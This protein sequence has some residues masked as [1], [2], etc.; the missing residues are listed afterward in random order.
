MP[1]FDVEVKTEKENAYS[2]VSQNE[3][4]LQFYNLGFFNPQYADQA[5]ACMDM[6]DFKGKQM[7]TE[8]IEANGGMYQQMMQLQQ[9]MLQLAEMVDQ[10][11]G[12]QTNMADETANSINASLDEGDPRGGSSQI[13]T[14]NGGEASI[15]SKARQNAQSVTQ[16]R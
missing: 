9:Q 16:P 14:G 7:V 2:Q 4:A 5:L 13:Y 11:S 12:G 6:M 8:K 15:V 1:V 10:L 3:L